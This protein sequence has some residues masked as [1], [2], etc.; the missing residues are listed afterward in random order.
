MLS[1]RKVQ[2]AFFGVRSL[3]GFLSCFTSWDCKTYDIT[4]CI[5][6]YDTHLLILFNRS[7]WPSFQGVDSS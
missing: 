1:L 2:F 5:T 6:I 3:T 7:S 4:S